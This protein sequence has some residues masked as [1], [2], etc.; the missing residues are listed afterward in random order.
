MS[1]IAKKTP[2]LV[3]CNQD[4]ITKSIPEHDSRAREQQL[5][6][7]S[8]QKHLSTVVDLGTLKEECLSVYSNYCC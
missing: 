4:S 1:N 5:S 2:W 3:E 7:D 6:H 8:S